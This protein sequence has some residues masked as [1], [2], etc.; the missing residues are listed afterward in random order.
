MPEKKI[1]PDGKSSSS[2]HKETTLHPKTKRPPVAES[3]EKPRFKGQSSSAISSLAATNLK[4]EIQ[5]KYSHIIQN[6][7]TVIF[8]PRDEGSRDAKGIFSTPSKETISGKRLRKELHT[9]PKVTKERRENHEHIS[10]TQLPPVHSFSSLQK[11]VDLKTLDPKQLPVLIQTLLNT[12]ETL[13]P[14][15]F[16]FDV[17]QEAAI[18]NWQL[19]TCNDMNLE[20]LLNPPQRCITSYGSEFKNSNHL[21]P[22]LQFHPR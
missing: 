12:K 6:K 15:L 13:H 4:N 9:S 18:H 7:K 17:S 10:K 21:E 1:P 11:P 16:R 14:P 19:M 5:G 8:N 2:H 3:V 20:H 22:L